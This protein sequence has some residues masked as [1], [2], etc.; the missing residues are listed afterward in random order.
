MQKRKYPYIVFI[1]AEAKQ[2][3]A[4]QYISEYLHTSNSFAWLDCKFIDP[5]GVYLHVVAKPRPGATSREGDLL[6]HHEHILYVLS[7]HFDKNLGFE[8]IARDYHTS[9]A[10]QDR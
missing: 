9:T 6:I 1:T 4:D 3:F 10:G 7:A 5:D 2:L 8:S